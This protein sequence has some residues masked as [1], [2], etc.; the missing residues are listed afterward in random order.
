MKVIRAK[1]KVE[2]LQEIGKDSGEH[3][4][5]YINLRPTLDIVSGITKNFPQVG[6]IM[7]PPSLH[8]QTSKKVF[9]Y[10]GDQGIKLEPGEFN[11]GRPKKYDAELVAQISNMRTQGMPAKHISEHLE[12]P[13][14][15][16]YFYL[17]QR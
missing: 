4:E 16:V 1:N 11:V 6:R 5:V 9:K 12:M 3:G 17:Q 8:T 10:L 2:L 15:T 7:C 14:R 13:L